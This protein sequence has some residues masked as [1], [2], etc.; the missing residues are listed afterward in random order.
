MT[1]ET[2]R[3]T[4]ACELDALIGQHVTREAPQVFWEDSH[5]QFQFATEAEARQ[6]LA[7][8]YYQRF[9]PDVDWTKTVVREV[10][11]YRPYCADAVDV[12]I[13]VERASARFGALLIWREQARWRAAFGSH[14]HAE[15]RIAS[16]AICLAALRAAG[17]SLEVNFDRVDAQVRQ[18]S[19]HM[20]QQMEAGQSAQE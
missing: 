8:P 15:A 3:I 19:V 10:H 14:F 12:W 13:V 7:D 6:A 16:V 18:Y 5:G 17:L 11:A 20:Q 1:N 4:T 9:L 2:I